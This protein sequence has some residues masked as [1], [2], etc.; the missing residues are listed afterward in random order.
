ML[1][2]LRVMK[3]IHDRFPFDQAI[4]LQQSNQIGADTVLPESTVQLSLERLSSLSDAIQMPLLK[5]S[6]V[7]RQFKDMLWIGPQRVYIRVHST[8]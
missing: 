1:T 3:S 6:P 5:I 4:T 7:F 8:G 2:D